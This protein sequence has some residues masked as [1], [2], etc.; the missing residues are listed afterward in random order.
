M[1]WDKLKIFHAVAEAGSFTSATVLL[2]LSQSA[3]S[4]QIQS[5]EDDLKVKLFERHAR[6]LTLTEN[7][8]Y[9]F[10]TA[11]EVIGKLKEVETTLS[12]KK[13][14]PSGKLVVTT[15]LSFGTTWLTPR[16]QE[17]MD[18]NPEIEVEL[19][20][21]NKE[22]DLSTRQADIGIFMRRPKQLNYIQKKLVDIN[23]HIYGSPKYLEKYGYPKTLSDLN[24]HKFISFGKGA[25]SPVF[26][27]DWALKLGMK[28]NKKR[29]TCMR[30]NSVY[31][32]LLAVQSGVGLAAL[33]DYI[34][35]KQPNI[36]KVLPNIEGPIT[37]AHFVY[38]A[39]L[40]NV[41]RVTSFRNFLYSK[42]QE[43]EF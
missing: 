19:V 12:D 41:A 24:K 21:D 25:P 15:V 1:D 35:M 39:S 17:F 28:D 22:L 31:G 34:T 13:D 29:K 2:N 37:E 6:G 7:G 8:E 5:L 30:V 11:H 9:V 14:K 10:K 33:P 26:N 43:W 3:I 20:F 16:I 40:K 18:L 36:V 32:L 27:P 42:I 38:P 4:R 23:Y